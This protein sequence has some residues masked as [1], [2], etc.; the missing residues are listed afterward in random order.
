MLIN[1]IL[2]WARSQ[3]HKPALIEGNATI[4]YLDFARAVETARL[5]LE[6]ESLPSGHF[7]FVFS[8]SF[9]EHWILTLAVRS[10]GL[11]TV[12][13]ANLEQA[14]HLRIPNV[15]AIIAPEE[16]LANFKSIPASLKDAKPIGI[17]RSVYSIEHRAALPASEHK[18]PG[19]GYVIFTSGTTGSYK[20]VLFDGA[21]ADKVHQ[22][23]DAV[24]PLDP[25]TVYHAI[26][27]PPW[28]G[29][30]ERIPISTWFA[31]G[32]V[33]FSAGNDPFGSFFRHRPTHAIVVPAM[34][35]PLL[36]A[37][38]P[39]HAPLTE[40]ELGVG[41]G[42]LPLRLAERVAREITPK[43]DAYYGSSEVC[44]S[45]RARFKTQ[46]D[47]SWLTPEHCHV[48][49]VDDEGRECPAFAQGEMR[50]RLRDF[51][52]TGY[53][54]DPE[55]TAK[56][57]RNGYFY[58]GDFA[59]RREDGRIRIL[60]RTE[61]V[62]NLQG[63]KVPV[64]PLEERIQRALNI[65]TVC[66]FSEQNRRGEEQVV[67]AVEAAIRPSEDNLAG[68]VRGLKGF[69]H[70]RWEFLPAFPRTEGGMIKVDRRKLRLMLD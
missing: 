2:G 3:P 9:I 55:T 39:D 28:T 64:A 66:V 24:T 48:E 54:D 26:N 58:P 46:D 19:G 56:F 44:A 57:Y 32:S 41:G 63:W 4:T 17:A 30:G 10:L 22:W 8:R 15:A 69:E 21:F 7:A 65:D 23:M 52:S 59:V 14:G 51:D 68:A 16:M 29:I 67:V 61:D 12:C 53:I 36:N 13:A 1:R 47:L 25:S 11:H 42:F 33:V 70:V 45:M 50:I 60:G 31:G 62:V 35:P 40:L 43:L 6:V 27:F 49:V 34:L 18:G 5:R 20:K 38:P 37:R